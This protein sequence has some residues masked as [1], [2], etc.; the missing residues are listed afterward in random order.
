MSES[1]RVCAADIMTQPGESV[2]ERVRAEA[3]WA[4]EASCR[5]CGAKVGERCHDPSHPDLLAHNVR[6]LDRRDAESDVDVA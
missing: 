4:W 2:A 6:L 1:A 5:Q 3:E